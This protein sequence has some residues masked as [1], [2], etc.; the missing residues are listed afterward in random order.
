MGKPTPSS[1]EPSSSQHDELPNHGAAPREQYE[2]GYRKTPKHSRYKPG[3]SG[4]P[5]GRPRGVRNFKTDV[6]ATLEARVKVK[7]ENARQTLSTQEAAL[8]RLREKALHGDARALDRL[9]ALAQTYNNDEVAASVNMAADD[10][11]LLE[12][13]QRRLLSGAAERLGAEDAAPNKS[14]A[15]ELAN[16][17][18]GTTRE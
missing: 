17:S 7:G 8:L 2:I 14:S 12:L 5:K 16:K 13:Y 11:R 6:K 9:I 4:N 18:E 10:T 15:T 1:A 3:Q